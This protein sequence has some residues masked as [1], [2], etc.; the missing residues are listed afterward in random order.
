MKSQTCPET[1]PALKPY[2][3]GAKLFCDFP[4]G[5][6]PEAVCLKVIEPGDGNLIGQGQI[7]VRL[8][9]TVKAYRKGEV[10]TLP[11]NSAVPK[12]QRLRPKRGEFFT[13]IATNYQ[14]TVDA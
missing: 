14:W 3:K 11:A 10:L 2:G 7:R 5:G 4:F 8:T 13:R 1:V 6:K 12:A 9:K